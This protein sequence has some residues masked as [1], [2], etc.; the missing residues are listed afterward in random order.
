M[1]AQLGLEVIY[2]SFKIEGRPSNFHD[3]WSKEVH[4]IKDPPKLK[5]LCLNVT[6]SRIPWN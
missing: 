4:C 6:I 2:K 1:C 3:F 5:L